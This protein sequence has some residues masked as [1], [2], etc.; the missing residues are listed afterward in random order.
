MSS[1]V[2]HIPELYG[3]ILHFLENSDLHSTSLVSW[4]F[5]A[6]GRALLFREIV[7]RSGASTRRLARVL[8]SSSHLIQ[9]I[10]LLRVPIHSAVLI[11]LSNVRFVALQGIH[12][13]ELEDTCPISLAQQLI[14]G[15][16]DLRKV[17]L[18]NGVR[19]LMDFHDFFHN[20]PTTVT[21]LGFNR[22]FLT[23]PAS[24]YP[25]RAQR[26]IRLPLK[27]LEFSHTT[28]PAQWFL[29]PSSPFDISRLSA[30][31]TKGRWSH[32][33]ARIIQ[34]SRSSIVSLTLP[35]AVPS[36]PNPH[37]FLTSLLDVLSDVLP[38]YRHLIS[39]G[40]SL[41]YMPD[42]LSYV[43]PAMANL[44]PD[45]TIQTI[46]LRVFITHGRVRNTSHL[47]PLIDAAICGAHLP[48]LR[49]VDIVFEHESDFNWDRQK[50]RECFPML[51]AKELLTVMVQ[52]R[53]DQY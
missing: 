53:Y 12:F 11:A 22:M 25:G 48:F 37:P 39:L 40:V 19:D 14:C 17:T 34:I 16:P 35:G 52:D 4:S 21:A 2:G 20:L 33:L 28:Y 9:L 18:S 49:H 7:L 10:R 32:A 26:N 51:T 5:A 44:A 24:L 3:Q 6:P 15:L 36:L 43:E 27:S 42:A 8:E 13:T 38:E 31:H 23:G 30:L 1:A 46:T 50:E 45:N 29:D 47:F 41:H